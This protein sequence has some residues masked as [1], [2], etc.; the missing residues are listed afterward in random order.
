MDKNDLIVATGNQGKMK[1]ISEICKDLPVSLYSL[2]DI[3]SPVPDIPE[4]ADTFVG[5]AELKAQWVLE[6]KSC[7]VLADDSGL[8]IDALDGR[9]GIYSARYAGEPSDSTKNI[10]K[11]LSELDGVPVEKRTARFRCVLA[12]LGPQGEKHIVEG[13]CEGHID[14]QP[15]GKGGFGYD[16]IFIPKGYTDSFAALESKVKNTI[17]HRG[18]A[19]TGL[20][21]VINSVFHK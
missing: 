3:W 13:I 6:R 18:K 9:P 17:S 7:W 20:L 4:T 10:A 1:E 21:D 5:N 19:L 2:K 12:L 16:P 11:V 8:Q 14:L 15:Y